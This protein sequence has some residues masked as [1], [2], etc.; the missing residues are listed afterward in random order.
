M[1]LE[2]SD[3]KKAGKFTKLWELNNK[4]EITKGIR[5]Y[6]EAKDENTTR[7]H[8]QD[9]MEAVLKGIWVVINAYVKI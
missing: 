3:R 8:W 5:E 2:I 6:L 1:K 9:T 4:E 7:Q